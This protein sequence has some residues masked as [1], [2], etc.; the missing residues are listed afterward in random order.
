MLATDT[1]SKIQSNC[2]TAVW[3]S[4]TAQHAYHAACRTNHS[5]FSSCQGQQN[6]KTCMH[7]MP[8]QHTKNMCIPPTQALETMVLAAKDIF[9]SQ[10]IQVKTYVT[11]LGCIKVGDD[12]PLYVGVPKLL[13]LLTQAHGMSSSTLYRKLARVAQGSKA[14][15][16]K[17]HMFKNGWVLARLKALGAVHLKATHVKVCSMNCM[18]SL[19]EHLGLGRSI[20]R[21]VVYDGLQESG[22]VLAAPVVPPAAAAMAL[23]AHHAEPSPDVSN[24]GQQ[25]AKYAFPCI[26]PHW[27]SRG[28][29]QAQDMPVW[30]ASG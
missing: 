26:L 30:L 16:P 21:K 15:A 6:S 29:F 12:G 28:G 27:A 5:M 19:V 25:I 22:T 11:Q 13:A 20:V 18:N 10:P 14:K 7:C 9:L 3:A 2:V 8:S 1:S 4:S 23:A 24:G 17:L